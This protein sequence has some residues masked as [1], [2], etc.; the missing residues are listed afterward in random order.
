MNLRVVSAATAACTLLVVA[1]ATLIGSLGA[2]VA[3][4][5]LPTRAASHS[6]ATLP[7]RHDR[8]NGPAPSTPPRGSEPA[9]S[10][11]AEAYEVCGVTVSSDGWT[12]PVAADP[13]SGFRT[14]HRPGHDGVDLPVP[15]GTAVHAAAAGTVLTVRCD[16]VDART[17]RAW[18]CDR[19]G[20]PILTRGCGWYLDI[21][22]PGRV[23]TRYCH[24]IRRPTSAEGDRV[25]A[26]DV[27]GFAGSSGHSSGPHLHFEVHHGTDATAGNAVEPVAFMA[28]VGAPLTSRPLDNRSSPAAPPSATTI[29]LQR[30]APR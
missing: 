11:S 12:R 17:G 15:A 6:A 19:P 26:G 28:A 29:P 8:G 10:A 7:T 20:D 14:P 9:V 5:C 21:A 2:S 16:A 18:G 23:I 22:H 25:Q 1:C 3:G 27:V 24:L 13:G 30:R 4:A